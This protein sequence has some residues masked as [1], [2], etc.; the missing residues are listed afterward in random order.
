[1]K[2]CEKTSAVLL[3]IIDGLTDPKSF[4][5]N[6]GLFPDPAVIKVQIAIKRVMLQQTQ[7][8]AA[9]RGRTAFHR[10]SFCRKAVWSVRGRDNGYLVECC[11]FPNGHFV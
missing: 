7:K 5:K 1:M 8:S 10:K 4:V 9:M 6:I 11:F 2:C 3:E